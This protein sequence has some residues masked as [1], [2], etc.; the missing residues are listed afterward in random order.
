VQSTSVGPVPAAVCGPLQYAPSMQCPFDA[1]Q[2]VAPAQSASFEQVPGH[3][4][5]L[6]SQT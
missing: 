2:C 1:S 4:A 6:P 3:V 5:F